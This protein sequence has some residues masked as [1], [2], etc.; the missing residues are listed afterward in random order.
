M[1][2]KV[3]SL[4]VAEQTE[5]IELKNVLILKGQEGVYV[6]TIEVI[7]KDNDDKELT[8]KVLTMYPWEKIVSMAWNEDSLIESVK[9]GVILEALQ[10]LEDFLE[11]YEDEEEE[12]TPDTPGD[13]SA[14]SKKR[15]DPQVNPY[16]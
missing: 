10:D 12:D 16:E 15:D 6:E 13:A 7:G 1:Q 9:Q 4:K 11:D 14:D 8:Q 3:N 2:Q 5:T